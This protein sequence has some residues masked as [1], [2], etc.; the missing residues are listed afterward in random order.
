MKKITVYRVY[1]DNFNCWMSAEA[2]AE[3]RLQMS[4]GDFH[5]HRARAIELTPNQY[6][7]LIFHSGRVTVDFGPCGDGED[8]EL[9]FFYYDGNGDCDVEYVY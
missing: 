7:N 9:C 4:T 3:S 6:Q 5:T 2:Y 8:M 1:S